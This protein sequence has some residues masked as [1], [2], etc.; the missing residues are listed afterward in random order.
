MKKR[1]MKVVVFFVVLEIIITIVN[2]L[3]WD[4]VHSYTRLMI[5]EMYQYEGNIDVVF[6]GASHVYRSYD[7]EIADGILQKNTFNAGSSSQDFCSSYYLLKEISQYHNVDTVYFDVGFIMGRQEE[8][9]KIAVNILSAY[10]KN[11]FNKISM[12]WNELG[13]EA[14][15]DFFLPVRYGFKVNFISLYKEKLSYDYKSGGYSYVTYDNEEYKGNGFVY[16]YLEADEN[17]AFSGYII[18]EEKPLSDMSLK[19]LMKMIE[20]CDKNGIKLV[21]VESPM[22]DATLEKTKGYQTYLNYIE[23]IAKENQ[24]EFLNFNLAKNKLLT[25][26][27]KDYKD[28]NHLNGI[29]AK[30]YTEAF[31]NLIIGL[32][33]GTINKEDMFFSYYADKLKNNFDDTYNRVKN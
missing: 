20:Y 26:G 30:K 32:K 14:V 17:T 24:I 9:S 13:L 6:L 15:V 11:G 31:C 23:Q 3:F 25:M 29:G 12:M 16:S 10:M 5:K 2:L 27:M 19:Y 33:C 22:P 18:D 1:I 28:N 21:L 8:T 7:T 4:N